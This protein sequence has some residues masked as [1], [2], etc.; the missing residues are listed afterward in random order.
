MKVGSKFWNGKMPSIFITGANRGLGLEFV[1]QYLDADWRVFAACR[2]PEGAD[3]LSAL[4]KAHSELRIIQ[5]DVSNFTAIAN[6]PGQLDGAPIDVL[7]NNAGVFGPKH[8][9]ENDPRQSFG[10]ID[11]GVWLDVVR[12][13]ALS[14]LKITEALLPNIKAGQQKKVV[15]ISSVMGSI[16]IGG[17]GVYAYRNSKAALNMTMQALAKDL[18]DDGVITAALN[19]GWVKTD[20][21]GPMASVEIED[22]IAGMRAVIDSLTPDKSG[23]FIDYDGAALDW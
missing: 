18:A 1:K 20:M 23:Q 8:K 2:N 6:F 4:A 5:L 13:N 11:E 19:P 12:T 3:D 14:P 17:P 9:A 7:I 22:S 15:A 16:S 10:S 21:G